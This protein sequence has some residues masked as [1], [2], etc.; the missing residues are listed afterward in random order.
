MRSKW[1]TALSLVLV[2]ALVLAFA[3][4]GKKETADQTQDNGKA[5]NI[6]FVN[7]SALGDQS[8]GD[9]VKDA[10]DDFCAKTGSKVNVYEC[11][12][13]ASKYKPAMM[14]VCASGEYDVVITGFYNLLEATEEAAAKYPDQKIIIFD[15]LVDYSENK[16]ANVRSV[17]AKQNECAFLAGALAGLMTESE[18]EWANPE[19]VVGFVGAAENTAIQDF[20]VGYIDGVNYINPEIDVLYSFVGNWI[21]SAKAKELGLSQYQQGADVSFAVCGPAG[22][23]VAE[24][25][26]ESGRYN[27]GVDSDVAA[28]I[29]DTNPETAKHIVTS[30]IKDFYNIITQELEAIED[31]SMKWGTEE[32]YDYKKGGLNLIVN[33]FFEKEVPEDVK[34]KFNEVT[35]KLKAGEIEVSSAIGASTAEIQEMYKKAAPFTN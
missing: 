19:K 2:L 11:N 24:A 4:C 34:A 15:A 16:N 27:I 20:L 29:K 30:A 31:G 12:N 5:L 33:E 7:Q 35:E 32:I 21:D 28:Q 22:L 13:D 25:A 8:I 17:L 10:I 23:G 14:D 6:M 1:K 9:I 26:R 3:G 18:A